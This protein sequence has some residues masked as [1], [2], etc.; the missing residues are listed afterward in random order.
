[1][2]MSPWESIGR[3]ACNIVDVR[4]AGSIA[5][6]GMVEGFGP[7]GGESYLVEID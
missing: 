3:T 5:T 4:R 1:M 2:A 7:G 6:G